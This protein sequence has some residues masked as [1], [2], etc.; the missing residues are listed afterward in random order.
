MIGFYQ[1]I[2]DINSSPVS[3]VGARVIPGDLKYADINEDNVIDNR[4]RTAIGYTDIPQDVYGLEPTLSF[5]GFTLS[6]LFQAADKVSSNVL[7]LETGRLQYYGPMVGRWT[8]PEDSNTAT[9]P[10]MKPLNVGDNASY[11]LNSFLMQDAR[12]IKLRNVELS[13][14]LPAALLQRIKVQSVRVYA[15]G[16]NLYTWTKFIGLDP[17]NSNRTSNLSNF[18]SPALY[19]ITR[20]FNLGMNVQF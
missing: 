18:V 14:S 17:E 4:D 20:I 1:D 3:T 6:A 12:Y 9:W 8:K 19:P 7:N 2:D 5:M 15:N 16:Q 13:Y 10:V 11:Q